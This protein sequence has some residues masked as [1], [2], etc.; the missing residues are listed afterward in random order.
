[1]SGFTKSAN[2]ELLNGTSFLVSGVNGQTFTATSTIPYA[3]YPALSGSLETGTMV[4][5]SPITQCA[6]LPCANGVVMA[7]ENAASGYSSWSVTGISC[8][9]CHI[10]TVGTSTISSD[11]QYNAGHEFGSVTGA[12]STPVIP[13]GTGATALCMEC[14]RLQVAST[15]GAA[16]I[17]PLYPPVVKLSTAGVYSDGDYQGSEFLNS[18]HAQYLGTLSQNAQGSADTSVNF[19]GTYSSIFEG[20]NGASSTTNSGCTG[21]HDPHQ[22]IVGSEF[23][24]G[25]LASASTAIQNA[26]LLQPLTYTAAAT[27]GVGTANTYNNLNFG[28]LMGSGTVQ[29]NNCDNCHSAAGPGEAIYSPSTSTWI[30]H[31]VGPGTMFPNSSNGT[32]NPVDVPGAC[33]VCHMEGSS[34]QPKMHLFRINP[35]GTYYTYNAGAYSGQTSNYNATSA[36]SG[37]TVTGTNVT[38]TTATSIAAVGDEIT[39]STIVP[40][41]A[42]NSYIVTGIGTGTFT[43]SLVPLGLST[44]AA[45][46]SGGTATIS[47]MPY[48]NYTPGDGEYTQAGGASTTNPFILG[49]DA[50]GLDVDIACGQCHG[51]GTAGQNPYGIAVPNPAPPAFTRTYLATAATGMHNLTIPPP[52]LTPILAPG[53]GTFNPTQIVTITSATAGAT[54][55]YTTDGSKP[56]A[57]TAGTCDTIDP[58]EVSLVNGGNFT[59]SATTTVEAIATLASATNSVV[60]SATYTLGATTSVTTPTFA[61]PAGTYPSGTQ[62]VTITSDPGTTICYTTNGTTPVIGTTAG[63]CSTTTPGELSLGP[64]PSGAA[65]ISVS[66]TETVKA[67]ATISTVT[68]ASSTATAAYTISAVATTPTFS[69]AAG[70]YATV[71]TVNI[72]SATSGATICYTTNGTAPTAAAA[73]TCD[74]NGGTESSLTNGGSISV[75]ASETVEAIAT[76]AAGTNSAAASASYTI[77]LAQAAAPTFG[78]APGIYYTPQTVTL[79]DTTAGA[80]TCYTTN[81][82]TPAPG[83][84]AG[85]CATG[86]PYASF[87]LSAPATIAAI[88]GGPN[89]IA[90]AVASETVTIKALAPSFSPGGGTYSGAETVKITDNASSS[91]AT[92]YY[93]FNGA[94]TTA[95]LSCASPCSVAVSASETLEAV[96]AY[97]AGLLSE[98]ST[99]SATYKINA[100]A[101]TFSPAAGTYKT[102]QN[103]V[104]SDSLN[105]TICYTTN[106]TSPVLGATTGTCSVGT[107]YTAAIPLSSSATIYA[108]AGLNGYGS[109]TL[110]RAIYTIP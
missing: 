108:I 101:P 93:A 94:P 14:H 89:F 97:D 36:I 60:A 42:N 24:G 18:P 105:V 84:T 103:I 49:G 30:Q 104:L 44:M 58:T 91:T 11:Y 87:V 71:Q 41:V 23:T 15:K 55:C 99:T 82:T 85:T 46:S 74:S 37:Y 35:S 78:L 25:P 7:P 51:G 75:G 21:C 33:M 66:V 69:V 20:V 5:L 9:R 109:S 107:P 76:F 40:A 28:A 34:G 47:A 110:V 63:T 83:T 1:V 32:I 38:F 64:N 98:S 96:A 12:V 88:A 17:S 57:A 4:V 3:Y 73:G 27:T 100:P 59:L 92:I 56:T 16:A 65:T 2:D 31:P 62:T 79:S 39:V 102:T 70:T 6:A 45:Y 8:E 54:I 67:I 81:G 48:N 13:T 26:N 86:T 53:T 95:S 19:T 77:N 50:I 10:A 61:P 106:G 29:A 22:T 68:K 72:T 90:S 52:A 43:A 80:T